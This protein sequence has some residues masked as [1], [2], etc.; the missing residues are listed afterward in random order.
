MKR[1]AVIGAG[2][3]GLAAA[4]TLA[5]GHA[6]TLF[7]TSDRF[8]GH[9]HTVDVTLGRRTHG[10]DIGVVT[11]NPQAAPKFSALLAELGVAT[12]PAR[13]TFSAQIPNAGIEWCSD[14]V[15]GVFAQNRNLARPA[16][17]NMLGEIVRFDRH[18]TALA[19]SA[20]AAAADDS[21]GDF[22]A[23][24]RF[25]KGFRDWY[26]LPLLACIWAA[27]PERLL[28][29]PAAATA[30]FCA[31]H[32]LLRGRGRAGW[33]SL[34][35][36]TEDY[37]DKLVATIADARLATPVRRV[38]RL[39][40]GGAEVATEHGSER[41][42]AVVFACHSVDA[43]ALLADPR[44]DERAALGAIHYQRNRAILHTDARVLP[45]RRRAWAAF[46]YEASREGPGEDAGACVHCFVNRLQPLPFEV[47]VIVS[48]NPIHEPEAALVQGEFH[49]AHPLF[50]RAA[51]AAQA[52]L[53]TLQGRADTWYCGGWTR[54]GSHEDALASAL[55]VCAALGAR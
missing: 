10:V 34:R 32:G 16:F 14:G 12:A 24:H 49:V 38:R 42:D 36:A 21:V 11:F 23:A 52:R 35:G 29:M 37:V 41:F 19:R 1:V 5:G 51:V 3:A 2:I 28:R 20:A 33:R 13:A 6:V 4:R 47:P 22:L 15:G 17:W 39:P 43:L 26:L 44:D 25:S 45:Q 9:A 31:D 7:E 48:L 55:E 40:I 30:R 18:A 54:L 46:N 27:P 8:G 50:D 53:A